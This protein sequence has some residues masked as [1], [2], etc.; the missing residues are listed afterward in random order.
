MV[1]RGEIK[2][3]IGYMALAFPNFNPAL[4]GTPNSVDV[5]ADLLGDLDPDLLR[6]AVRDACA[7]LGRRFAPSP[8]EIRAA[9]VGLRARAA[10]TP[11]AAEAWGAV[12]ESFRRVRSQAPEL[13]QHP[14]VA[15]AIHCMGGLERIGMSED[16][17]VDRAHF[18]KIY[19]QLLARAQEDSARLPASQEYIRRLGQDPVVLLTGRLLGDKG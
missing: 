1:S 16:N 6:L 9:A 18:M 2:S 13:L 3:V 7:E 4:E 10:G 8:G 11:S 5:Y 12:M 19:E 14:L 17:M 15:K